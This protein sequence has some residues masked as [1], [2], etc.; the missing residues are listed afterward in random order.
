M[1]SPDMM[2]LFSAIMNSKNPQDFALNYIQGQMG[3]N[4]LFSQLIQL[5]QQ[6]NTAQVEQIARQVMKNNGYDYDREFAKFKN[7]Y[8][9]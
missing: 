8:R 7:T 5:G 4:P 6:G 1:N 3:N 9:I 2:K